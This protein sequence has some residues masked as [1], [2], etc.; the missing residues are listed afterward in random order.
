MAYVS[1]KYKANTVKAQQALQLI[2][3]KYIKYDYYTNRSKTT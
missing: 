2:T 3:N 1:K